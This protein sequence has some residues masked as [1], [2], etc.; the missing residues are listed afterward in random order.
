VAETSPLPQPPRVSVVIPAY[1]AAP[2]IAD[3]LE[4][5]FAQT[6]TDY[7][8]IVVNDGSPDTP[9]FEQALAPYLHRLVYL[10][11]PNTGPSGA[12]N[13]AIGA[14][15]G[16]Y[17]AFLDS[18]DQWLPPYLA[19]QMR[20][21]DADPGLDVLY[22]DG[23]I[24][25]APPLAGRTLMSV[26]PSRGPV[27]FESLVREECTVLMTATIARR[28]RIV[29]AGLFDER[30]LR[31]ED[32]HLWLRLVLMGARV[33]YTRRV[34]VRHRRREGSLAH[35]TMAMIRAFIDVVRD[36][37]ARFP[38]TAGQRAIVDGHLAAREAE[39]ALGEGKRH[40]LAGHNGDALAALDRACALETRRLKQ[41]RLRVIRAAVRLAPRLLRRTYER[42]RHPPA[43]MHR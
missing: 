40:L 31:S 12:R 27:T 23:L 11:Q 6:F 20:V 34:L 14:A 9:D 43:A 18:D 38:L 1:N 21:L 42:L 22:A 3:T 24:F 37:E 16:D 36:V 17:V 7:E 30:F 39:L 10:K 29:D 33:A 2:F 5:V 25:G 19:E 15:R 13:R 35:D 8:V 28:Q 41:L 4:S 26:S 32:F